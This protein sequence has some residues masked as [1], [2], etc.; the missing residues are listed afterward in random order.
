[1]AEGAYRALTDGTSPVARLA[2]FDL[3]R[4]LADQGDTAGALEV[5]DRA[6][7]G[8]GAVALPPPARY[9]YAELLDGTGRAEEA[10]AAYSSYIDAEPAL[11]GEVGL[12][13]GQVL[14]LLGRFDAALADFTAALA[15]APDA[16]SASLAALR[17]GNALLRVGTP[18]AAAAA[19][20]DA[21]RL[22]PNDPA[23][24]QALAGLI[25]AQADSGDLAAANATRRRLIR[26]LP[27]NGLALAA[28]ARL[29]EAGESVAPDQAAA[30][31]LGNG[32]PAAAVTIVEAAMTARTSHPLAWDLALA[33]ARSDLGD[34]AGALAA[35][36]VGL[37]RAASDPAAAD[38]ALLR[39]ELLDALDRP[40]DAATAYAEVAARFPGRAADAW[41]AR[42][43]LLDR[44]GAEAG[45]GEAY[46]AVADADAG[47]PRAGV[48]RFRAGLAHWRARRV[49][50]AEAQWGRLLAA[51]DDADQLRAGYWLG[52]SADARGDT[53]TAAA[54]WRSVAAADPLGY[55]GL[56]AAAR[57]GRDPALAPTGAGDG[58]ADTGR[59][60]ATWARA[61][62]NGAWQ[63]TV[64]AA[65]A[66]PELA[67]AKAW[68]ALGRDRSARA[69]LVSAAR[70][71]A[72]DP[73]TRAALAW[74]ASAL[75]A[76]RAA[77]GLA[78]G[79]LAAAPPT[80]RSSAPATFRRL[81]YPHGHGDLVR[82]AAAAEGVPPSLLF[83]LVRQESAFEA[84][85]R[86]SAGA[87]GLTQVMP[88]TGLHLA[89]QLG[90]TDFAVGDLRRPEVALRLGA[91]YL[92][93]QWAD[94]D[95]RPGPALAAYNGGPGNASRWWRAA[96]GD[97]DLFVEV[98]D[99]PET[100][101]YVRK[102][103]EQRAAYEALYGE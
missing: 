62:R 89:A 75:G 74:H 51:G 76:Q 3:A 101:S 34:P 95:G 64:A 46:A 59:W 26:E 14:F 18:A 10:L 55:Y 30:V 102:V 103:I 33:R 69:E 53:V 28:L 40:A 45:L 97:E 50:E 12:E 19:Y 77:M 54:R 60:L 2:A 72:D 43:L 37:A 78:E 81:A 25:G 79:V 4:L 83:A 16:E 61:A 48:A 52:R 71:L 23:R 68:L 87:L 47:H 66:R 31:W 84:D 86:S 9:L 92:A 1:M 99:F 24:A 88:E 65:A 94:Y 13:R 6:S 11:A 32:D 7:G 90:L 70:T 42:A 29:K 63:D 49:V 67:R 22:A 57:L 27:A 73:A 58:L 20:E 44:I 38:A 36:E 80:A 15:A 100:A 8:G 91:H 56:R 93:T 35:I 39:A 82:S 17:R 21:Y 85:A 5:L 98:I 96:G 41:W